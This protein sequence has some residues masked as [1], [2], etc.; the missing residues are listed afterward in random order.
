M[1]DV[2]KLSLLLAWAVAAYSLI[3]YLLGLRLNH[4]LLLSSARGGI[5][6][7]G[8][9]TTV[10]SLLLFYLLLIGD[11]SVQYVY[12][13][14]NK[15]L[16]VF[17]KLAA[18]WAGN[19]GSLLLWAWL[20]SIFAVI[21]VTTKKG[22]LHKLVPF[23][24]LFLL[25][26][27]FF[28]LILL[29]VVANPFEKL[30]FTPE[31][32]AGLNPLLQNPGMVIH[33]VT[34]YLGYVGFAIPFAWTMAALLTGKMDGEW[35]KTMRRWSLI[36]WLFL[37]LGNIYGAQWAYVELGWGG[38]W[39]WDP[40]ENASL[41]PW[42]TGTALIHSLMIQERKG[43]LKIWNMGLVVVTYLLTIF[44]TFLTRSGILASVHAFGDNLLGSL[45][46]GFL[47]FMLL[48]SLYIIF[49][50]RQ[51]LR[52]EAEL[53][54]YLSR[55]SSFLINNL[56]F[57]GI[58][59]AVFW[60]T[61]LPK[62]T[63]LVRGVA[64]TVSPEFFNQVTGPLF[65]VMLA[66]MALCPL[67]TW[68]KASFSKLVENFRL[69]LA[70]ALVGGVLVYLFTQHRDFPALLGYTVAF[71]AAFTTLREYFQGVKVRR[72]NTGES[73][74][75]AFSNLITR[76]KRRWGGYLAHLGVVL[77]AVGIIG[78]T[79]YQVEVTQ[80][81]SVGDTIKIGDY[82]LTYQGL[83]EVQEGDTTVVYA[84]MPVTYKGKNIGS[85]K[86]EKIFYTYWEQPSTE[87]ALKS[88]L[89][90]DLYVILSGWE[91]G[92]QVATFKVDINPL[93]NVL[94]LGGYVLTFGTI[95]A[96]WPGKSSVTPRYV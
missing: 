30:N 62:F 1:A 53:E 33:P 82:V 39:A 3:S 81:V 13:Y 72:Q 96:L 8:F 49:A 44:G 63:E 89:K 36:A 45:F 68:R 73:W 15:N 34:L 27:V 11:F 64:V 55:E 22:S 19:A 41:M 93:V 56:L 42:L 54:S 94:W 66:L 29:N 83:R 51:L 58:T 28:F 75:A 50:N 46:L 71:F 61:M 26:N 48:L 76:N 88:S 92:G 2:G 52:E 16:P 5:L 21:I 47:V 87:V 14:T 9:L 18:F 84:E 59:F 70:L 85:V 17:Y 43:M 57:A 69:P 24:M 95:F 6:A 25:V 60:G 10:A 78:S 40:V 4:K 90:E 79:I 23:V 80:T 91:E 67:I 35:F 65:L 74:V 20:L 37:T 86:P 12:A 77:M 38:Y 31:D 32:G 7:V